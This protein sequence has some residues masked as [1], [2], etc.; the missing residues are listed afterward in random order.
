MRFKI[1]QAV[2]GVGL[3]LAS[4]QNCSPYESAENNAL[5]GTDVDSLET[6]NFKH[7]DNKIIQG[8]SMSTSGV[9]VKNA[10]SVG[11]F[12]NSASVSTTFFA[13]TPGRY[14]IVVVARQDKAG[15]EHAKLQAYIDG[16]SQGVV[17]VSSTSFQPHLLTT[18]LSAGNRKIELKFIN[19]AKV[20]GA[21]RNVY[22]DRII[23][24]PEANT[25]KPNPEP[26][27]PI[28]PTPSLV[29]NCDR[30]LIPPGLV[31]VT[32]SPSQNLQAV[33]DQAGPGTIIRLKAGVYNQ[34]LRITGARFDANSAS[35]PLIITNADGPGTAVLQAPSTATKTSTIYIVTTSHVQINGLKIVGNAD[36]STDDGPIKIINGSSSTPALAND[37]YVRISNNIITGRGRD[38]IKVGRTHHLDIDSNTFSCN[39]SD[40]TIDFVTVWDTRVRNNT[41]ASNSKNGITMKNG[42]MNIDV[43]NNHFRGSSFHPSIKIGGESH[44]QASMNPPSLE[45]V[46]FEGKNIRVRHNGIDSLGSSA[47][48]FQGAK[49]STLEENYLFGYNNSKFYQAMVANSS[50]WL[51]QQSD[52]PP[53]ASKN[54]IIRNNI[55]DGSIGAPYIQSGQHSGFV[56]Q[57]NAKGT[58]A[59]ISYTFGVGRCN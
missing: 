42:S 39:A 28:E 50:K 24:E 44:S 32:V 2:I 54:N 27:Q 55:L 1:I 31:V 45:F 51:G 53:Y 38:C 29:A 6:D 35:R 4:F 48:W 21:D 8:E 11:L 56:V 3:V 13:S 7:I 58:R 33:I 57:N 46:G 34:T 37:G 47:V 43:F 9:A 25:T 17:E 36:G 23:V 19:D 16:K 15:T 10:T 30:P 49:D 5:N 26:V 20:G 59:N 22:I 40:A 14:E 52:L 12:T 18:Y 41:L